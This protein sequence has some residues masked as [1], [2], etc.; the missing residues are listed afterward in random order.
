MG[1]Q[2]VVEEIYR[3]LTLDMLIA[4]TKGQWFQQAYCPLGENVESCKFKRYN[5]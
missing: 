5:H 2:L 1:H 4:A 3:Q